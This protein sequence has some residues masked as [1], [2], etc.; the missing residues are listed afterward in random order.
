MKRTLAP[1]AIAAVLGI[2]ACMTNPATGKKQ[3][4]LV[5]ESQ[6]VEIGRQADKDVVA[7]IGL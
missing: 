2:T 1:L 5:G 3:I 6:E 7:Q 4:S